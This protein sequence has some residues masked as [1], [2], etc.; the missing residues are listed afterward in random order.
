MLKMKDKSMTNASKNKAETFQTATA[1][2]TA[3]MTAFTEQS[4]K[5]AK[6]NLD[7]IA[8]KSR[9]AMEQNIKT[10]DAVTAMTRGNVDAFLESS[11]V[12]SGGLQSIA[13]EVADYSKRALER[14]T[15]VA[16]SLTQAKTAPELMQLQSEFARAEFNSAIS[17]IAKLSEAMFKTM[18][19]TF[20]PLQKQAMA[21][22]QIKDLMAES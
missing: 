12:A 15:S 16:R 19:A 13:Q 1:G 4:I 8:I 20:E 5:Q 14:T 18:T 21:A 17:E 6:A 22:A 9:E 3:M 10:V 2:S 11:R 7:Q